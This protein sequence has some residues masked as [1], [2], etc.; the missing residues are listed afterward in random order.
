MNDD[1]KHTTKLL[2]RAII[3]GVV[4]V[5]LA[6][7][8]PGK[9]SLLVYGIISLVG[10]WVKRKKLPSVIKRAKVIIGVVFGAS[11]FFGF[12]LWYVYGNVV[13]SLTLVC[14][15]AAGIIMVLGL[16]AHEIPETQQ[17]D[18]PQGKAFV[19]EAQPIPIEEQR[20]CPNCEA[21]ISQN[22]EQCSWCGKSV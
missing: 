15:T 21:V 12:L 6:C 1:W 22:V 3:I 5:P 4:F 2:F 11:V 16:Y 10:L 9:L 17:D 18:E 7:F 8:F 14:A 19:I 20:K 13:P